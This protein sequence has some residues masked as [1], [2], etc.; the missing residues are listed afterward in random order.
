MFAAIPPLL[1]S[2]AVVACDKDEGKG[3][4]VV[5]RLVG[6]REAEAELH[7]RLAELESRLRELEGELQALSETLAG[8]HRGYDGRSERSGAHPNRPP[9][10]PRPGLS[11]MAPVPPMPP[12]PPM[13]LEDFRGLPAEAREAYR[14]AQERWGDEWRELQ[15][16]WKERQGELMEEWREQQAEWRDRWRDRHS[17]LME[18]WHERM[19]EWR[20]RQHE[21][22]EQWRERMHEHAEHA[23]DAEVG[24]DDE[25]EAAGKFRLKI[26]IPDIDIPDI[27]IPD[28]DVPGAEGYGVGAGGG[29][30]YAFGDG[31]RESVVYDLDGEHA[32]KLFELLAPSDVRVIV[33]RSGDTISVSGTDAE[34]QV[35]NKALQLLGWIDRDDEFERMTQGEREARKYELGSERAEMLFEMLAPSEVKVIVSRAGDDA[36]AVQGTDREH[37][38]LSDFLALLNWRQGRGG[39]SAGELKQ[40]VKAEVKEAKE[41][42]K[43]AEKRAKEALKQAEQRAKQA[44]KQTERRAKEAQKHAEAET[45]QRRAE[46]GSAERDSRTYDVKG[47]NA[48]RLFKLLAPDTVK[49]IVSR[50]GDGVTVQGTEREL[51]VLDAGLQLLG[52]IDRDESFE[53]MTR[54]DRMA[55][56]YDLGAERADLLYEMLAPNDVKVI[57]AR[58]GEETLSV[59]GTKREHKVLSDLLGLLGWTD[60]T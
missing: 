35:L 39:G 20:E 36:V 9:A 49:V 58:A 17:D 30:A 59:Q 2:D 7:A 38:V 10:V 28:V 25:D 33:S 1:A 43:K 15:D 19:Q 54:G 45:K 41:A 14:E 21:E 29:R 53:K 56:T 5:A 27:D 42:Q 32:D 16:Q 22:A 48:D 44:I 23:D 40:R 26:E 6:D 46:V 57:V 50:S 18:Q 11:P 34:R 13:A 31:E 12:V 4:D 51:A 3:A 8:L 52:W 37:E 55:E 24:E 60:N 47:E